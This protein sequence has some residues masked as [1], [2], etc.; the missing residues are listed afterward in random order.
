MTEDIQIVA[1]STNYKKFNPIDILNLFLEQENHQIIKKTNNSAHFSIELKKKVKVKLDS[2][3]YYSISDLTQEYS[4]MTDVDYYIIFVDLENEESNNIL[5]NILEYIKEYCELDK[6]YYVFGLVN[7]NKQDERVSEEKKI[8]E[9]ID[10]FQINYEYKEA[11]ISIQ[12]DIKNIFMDIF[13]EKIEEV[14]AFQRKDISRCPI[15]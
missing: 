8:K 1:F 10:K 3:K 2:I 9:I 13:K 11:N 4:G 7:S 6:E 14:L 15:H 12:N 5:E